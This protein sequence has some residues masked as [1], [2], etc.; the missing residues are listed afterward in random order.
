MAHISQSVFV[1]PF[2]FCFFLKKIH[3]LLII[4]TWNSNRSSDIVQL[5]IEVVTSLGNF[6]MITSYTSSEPLAITVNPLTGSN[7]T[8]EIDN[9]SGSPFQGYLNYYIIYP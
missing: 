7:I 3:S 1:Y 6:E 9:L 5:V 4:L 8:V 2:Y